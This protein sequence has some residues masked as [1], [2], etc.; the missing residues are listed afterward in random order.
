MV[1]EIRL[2]NFFSIDEEIIL[3]MRAANLNTQ[4]T[5]ELSHLTFDYNGDKILK[6]AVIYGA[7][8]SGKS[9]IIKAIRFCHAMVYE[10]HNH[11]EDSIFNFQPFKFNKSQ[12]QPSSYF[13]RFVAEDIEYA[14]SFSLTHNEIVK[15]SL[16]YYPQGKKAKVF[17]RDETIKGDKRDKYSFAK[18]VMK[19]P[20]DVV[21]NTSKKTLF[22]SRASQ[23]DREIPKVLFRYFH[24]TFIL[25]HSFFA[26]SNIDAFQKAYKAQILK[27]LQ[28]AD[29]DIVDFKVKV[30][31]EQTKR[32]R[33]KLDTE[34][35]FFED[36]ILE[37][38]QIKTYHRFNP[39]IAFDFFKEESLGTQKL[40]FMMLSII[41]VLKNKK[42]LLIDEIEDSLHPKIIEYIIELFHQSERSQL[43]FTTHNTHV[44][45]LKRFR[46]DQIWFVNKKEN[47]GSDFYS[48]YDYSDFRD[49]MD[50]EKAY[51]QGRFDSV[52]IV[53]YSG[54]SLHNLIDD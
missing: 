7:N 2:K 54:E 44:L 14:Y 27:A 42:V 49:S 39:K 52:P 37:S 19:R 28:L 34:E 9:N 30:I 5:R 45:D 15:E 12:N 24:N 17:E 33:A 18:S 29:S 11:N 4:K 38:L 23:M 43:I 31:K 8:A 3:D 26:A 10:S 40:F 6:S 16:Y 36:D 25:R 1:L 20:F 13:I 47:G 48:L 46:K 32:L 41:D 35:A 51:L 53:D 21:E 50:V 22:I